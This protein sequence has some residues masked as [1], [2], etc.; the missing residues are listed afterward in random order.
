LCVKILAQKFGTLKKKFVPL[1]SETECPV[2]DKK[3]AE[4]IGWGYNL[5]KY[6]PT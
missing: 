4:K 6:N 1:F 5:L 3:H 2:L